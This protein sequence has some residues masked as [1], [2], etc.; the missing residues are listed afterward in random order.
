MALYSITVSSV[1]DHDLCSPLPGRQSQKGIRA[2]DEIL[3]DPDM[4]VFFTKW[5]A[6][7]ALL[8]LKDLGREKT[9]R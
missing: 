5:I 1:R 8:Y 7:M 2:N 4:A 9:P 3:I 6:D